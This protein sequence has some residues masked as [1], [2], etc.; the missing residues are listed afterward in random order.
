MCTLWVLLT[1]EIRWSPIFSSVPYK[2]SEDKPSEIEDA[3]IDRWTCLV[4]SRAHLLMGLLE[5]LVKTPRS[6]WNYIRDWTAGEKE[7]RE[8]R[9]FTLN[10]CRFAFRS[11]GLRSLWRQTQL[12]ELPRLF[13]PVKKIWDTLVNTFECAVP[14]QPI[15]PNQKRQYRFIMTTSAVKS[16]KQRKI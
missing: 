3:R 2:K 5:D 1:Y 7:T 6:R 12:N 4:V 11:A 15:C 14:D 13:G 16:V 8:K 10:F 9:H